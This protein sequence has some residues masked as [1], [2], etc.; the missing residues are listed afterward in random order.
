MQSDSYDCVVLFVPIYILLR[1]VDNY[2]SGYIWGFY[3]V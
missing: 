2:I 3:S 1:K